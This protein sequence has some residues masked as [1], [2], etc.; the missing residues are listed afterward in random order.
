VVDPVGLNQVF[1]VCGMQLVEA[2]GHSLGFGY[3]GKTCEPESVLATGVRPV[4]LWPLITVG[5][6]GVWSCLEVV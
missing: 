1:F 3:K 6:L 2:C 4:S 5:N